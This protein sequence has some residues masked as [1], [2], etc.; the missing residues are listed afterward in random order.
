[1]QALIMGPNGTPYGHGAYLFDIYFED[2]YPNSP[3][4]V[5]LTTTGNGKVRFNPNLYNCGKVC[6]S[7]LGTWRGNAS[8]NWDPKVSTLLQVLVSIQSIIMTEDVYFNEPGFENQQGTEE[9][10]KKNEAYA[11]IVRLCNIKFAMI[12]NMK[13]PPKGFQSVI[14]RH[15]YLKK[16]EILEQVQKWVKY[17]SKRKAAYTSLVRDHN[18]TWCTEF[19]KSKTKY[20]EMLEEAITELETELNKLP[21]PSSSDLIK[22]E[23]QEKVEKKPVQIKPKE[24]EVKI[25]EIDVS[26]NQKIQE[27]ELN[28]DDEKVKDRWS[29]Y[30]G[31]M[32]VDAVSRQAKASILVFGLGPAALE[33]IKNLVLSGCKKLSIVDTK[34]VEWT[35]LSGQF[36]LTPEDVGKSRID[37]CLHKIQE[38]NYYVK[39]EKLEL[40]IGTSLD[41]LKDYQL[42]I[43]TQLPAKQQISINEFCHTNSIPFI[44]L[45]VYGPHARLFNDFESFEVL[46]KNGEDPVEVIIQSI[47]SEENG[48]VTVLKNMRHPYEDGDV[49][50]INKVEG[51]NQKAG[52]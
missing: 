45:D 33:M 34:Q 15:F 12:D 17:A 48:L 47:T 29:R 28:V 27:K 44:S 22:E 26:Y 3:P 20:K 32:G 10:E 30:I 38:L 21:I 35:D 42:V 39:V 16:D 46:D 6:L 11:N 36:F 4:K 5:N 52:G 40:D 9:G 2:T 18:A 41:K 51:M 19:E 24:E 50:T 7:L 25:D 43:V 49:V 31:A 37:R 1:M 23:E 13:N 8:E 14:K